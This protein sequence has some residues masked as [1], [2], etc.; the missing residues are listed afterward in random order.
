MDSALDERSLL[1][2]FLPSLATRETDAEP[3]EIEH[4]NHGTRLETFET[5]T[6]RVASK[7]PVPAN[8]RWPT[9][10][11]MYCLKY[12]MAQAQSRFPPP[13]RKAP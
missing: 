6:P 3:R 10:R 1:S 12:N 2:L 7:I 4:V 5:F 8:R 11:P 13:M 9:R